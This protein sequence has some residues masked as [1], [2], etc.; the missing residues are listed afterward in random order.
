MSWSL[1]ATPTAALG[2]LLTVPDRDVG[3][4]TRPTARA[5]DDLCGVRCFPFRLGGAAASNPLAVT[6]WVG[7]PGPLNWGPGI[8]LRGYPAAGTGF[9]PGAVDGSSGSKRG[10]H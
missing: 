8:R 6:S 9:A 4:D 5:M 7:N 10:S 2:P 3:G 1:P